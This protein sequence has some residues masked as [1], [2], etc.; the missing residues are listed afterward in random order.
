M[1]G[2]ISAIEMITSVIILF[3][4]FTIFFP[5]LSFK[6]EWDNAYLMM[7]GRDVLLTMDRTNK[8]QQ[9]SFNTTSMQNFVDKTFPR[10][11]TIIWTSIDDTV[12]NKLVIACNCTD[13]QKSQLGY[14]LR[15]LKVNGHSINSF[16]C[17]TNLEE[18]INPC[19][20]YYPDVLVIWGYKDFSQE[21]YEKIMKDFLNN[22]NGVVEIADLPLADSTQEHIF[23][24]S[25]SS[26]NFGSAALDNFQKPVN[27]TVS[28]YQ[29]YKYFYHIPFPTK[30][31]ENTCSIPVE[32][33]PACSSTET[34][35]GNLTFREKTVYLWICDRNTIYFD[36]NNNNIADFR[37]TVRSS[38][39]LTNYNFY[40]NYIENS[41]VMISFK[42]IYNFTDFKGSN[43]LYPSDQDINRILLS[44][45]N[46]S[47]TD[48][49]IPVVIINESIGK[50]AWVAVFSR[51]GL[52]N[53]KDDHK[54]LLISLILDV[55]N[56][57]AKEVTFGGVEVG[58]S[59]SYLD[60]INYDMFE[61][62]KINLG[63][64][65]PF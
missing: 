19:F 16:V 15:N 22:R 20:G 33:I 23:G 37:T 60:V 59:T 63:V 56:K 51:N 25:T 9:Y 18:K 50:T 58:R 7:T 28:T 52:N 10:N 2:Q 62:Y 4:A 46:Y 29:A 48:R 31:D 27:G 49:P 40:L 32:G 44:N 41:S 3:V 57:K 45:G 42:E 53:V 6:S 11:D 65:H 13:E 34:Q 24:I 26:D 39:N 8:L 64:G 5:G 14:W 61:F 21:K 55:S 38:F 54:Q 36:T 30:V 12:K 43:K 1:K 35:K 17:Y 47:G